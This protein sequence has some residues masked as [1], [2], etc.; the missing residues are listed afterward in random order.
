MIGAEVIPG[1]NEGNTIKKTRE[2]H[3]N[4]M[5]GHD[6]RYLVHDTEKR[7]VNGR[8]EEDREK[9]GPKRKRWS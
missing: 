9:G 3:T 1:L 4:E 7:S 5:G 2:C 8:K 6:R